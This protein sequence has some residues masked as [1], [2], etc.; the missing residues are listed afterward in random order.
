M[1]CRLHGANGANGEFLYMRREK[2]EVKIVKE[3]F[4]TEDDGD[5]QRY[6]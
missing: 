1:I 3:I 4:E 6:L 2:L 5:K